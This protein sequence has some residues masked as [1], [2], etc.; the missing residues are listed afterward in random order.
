MTATAETSI[1]WL[2][3]PAPPWEPTEGG[4]AGTI[5]EGGDEISEQGGGGDGGGIWGAQA[6]YY[7]SHGTVTVGVP[8]LAVAG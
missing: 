1:P 8:C 2:A 5:D 3:G 7:T 6:A 4:G